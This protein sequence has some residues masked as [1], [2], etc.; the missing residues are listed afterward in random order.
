MS[1][2]SSVES[3]RQHQERTLQDPRGRRER[4]HTH[5]LQPRQ[6]RMAAQTRYAQPHGVIV[7]PVVRGP[8]SGLD[9]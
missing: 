5:L 7:Q 4:P 6:R 1:S 3:V 2:C 8:S 9:V